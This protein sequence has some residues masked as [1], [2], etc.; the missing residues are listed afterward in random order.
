MHNAKLGTELI[1]GVN[2]MP[3]TVVGKSLN[4]GFIGKIARNVDNIVSGR[5]VKSILDG[6]GVETLSAI[7][8][9]KAVVLN[10][11]NTVS[12][13]GQSGSGVSAATA[14]LFAG[15]AV[16]EV[17]QMTSYGNISSA[18]Q[19]E[20]TQTCDV[21]ERGS[22][23]VKVVDYATNAPTAGGKVYICSAVGNGTLVLGDLYATVTPTGIGS[24]TV[25]ELTNVRFT[26]G[27]VDANGV[28]EVTVI[29]RNNP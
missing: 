10:T 12:L 6:S 26:T 27:K 3:G 13:F 28:S 24:G 25:L 7:P 20:P 2:N 17:K 21:L 29:T 14:A 5:F 4:L 15:F 16:G 18:G 23:T 1:K 9:G 8:F 11:D 22:V 19:Y